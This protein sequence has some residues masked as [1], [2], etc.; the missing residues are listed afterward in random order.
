MLIITS[1]SLQFH[2]FSDATSKQVSLYLTDRT[3]YVKVSIKL[4]LQ[5]QFLLMSF[6][7][8][9]FILYTYYILK[10][11]KYCSILA[12]AYDPKL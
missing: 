12:Y 1:N 8:V 9:I 11:F 4:R 6:R 7:T 2:G 3:Q 10:S 5:V